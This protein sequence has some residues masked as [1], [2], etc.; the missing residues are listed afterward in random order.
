LPHPRAAPRLLAAALIA[1]A[2]TT[3]ARGRFRATWAPVEVPGTGTLDVE[4][5]LAGDQ[6]GPWLLAGATVARDGTRQVAF[7]SAPGAGAW[8]RSATVTATPDGPLDT[9]TGLARDGARTV[10]FGWHP[11]P[12]HG[13]PRPSPWI[14]GPA[15]GSWREVRTPRE[16]FGGENV[17]SLGGLAGGAHGFTIAGTW[18]NAANRAVATVWR[19]AD[20]EQ[21]QRD[22]TDPALGGAPGELTSALGVAD[23]GGGLATVGDAIAPTPEDPTAERGA[24][25]ESPDGVGWARVGPRDVSLAG[26]GGVQVRVDHVA[27]VGD[28]WAAVG[29][30]AGSL[31]VLWSWGPRQPLVAS[32]VPVTGTLSS[33]ALAVAGATVL[34]GAVA[35]G[36]PHLWAATSGRL[37]PLGLPGG[38]G[39]GRASKMVLA[40]SGRVLLLVVDQTAGARAWWGTLAVT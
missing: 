8:A 34:V 32:A 24:L 35:G 21:W 19:S 5:A 3:G 22:D 14:A 23:G 10:G 11:S 18:V 28:G 39:D 40:A 4:A 9:I 20:G 12:I 13:I 25:W 27:A 16:L 6:S 1:A 33:T 29:S 15:A 31:V 26:G 7:W 17:I 36:R 38:A 37:A 30:R 2:C